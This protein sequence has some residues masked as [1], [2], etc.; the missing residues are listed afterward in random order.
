MILFIVPDKTNL[1]LHKIP[2]IFVMTF[3]SYVGPKKIVSSC[4]FFRL[5]ILEIASYGIFTACG[6][7]LTS[8]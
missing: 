4:Y 1:Y 8:F 7:N 2:E 6:R 5:D 3:T